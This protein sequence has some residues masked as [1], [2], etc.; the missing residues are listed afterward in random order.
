MVGLLL[1]V[2]LRNL[3]RDF[4]WDFLWD[5]LLVPGR[6][7]DAKHRQSFGDLRSQRTGSATTEVF[8]KVFESCC[9]VVVVCGAFGLPTAF[10]CGHRCTVGIDWDPPM[11]LDAQGGI[12]AKRQPICGWCCLEVMWSWTRSERC[13]VVNILSDVGSENTYKKTTVEKRSNAY[14]NLLF[15]QTPFVKA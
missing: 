13:V 15:P 9:R 7:L 10:P 6:V 4:L 3:L 12:K 1:G 11:C 2:L 5:L 8:N 14:L